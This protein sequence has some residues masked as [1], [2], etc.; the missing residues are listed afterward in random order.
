ML[1]GS[2]PEHS[3]ITVEEENVKYDII[4]SKEYLISDKNP[5]YKMNYITV[6]VTAN[7]FLTD[8]SLHHNESYSFSTG[9]RYPFD[10]S[11]EQGW[12]YFE[13]VF[14]NHPDNCVL[15]FY[16]LGLISRE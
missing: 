7:I 16:S 14:H 1:F 11:Q 2:Y 4:L 6:K 3:S 10:S 5:L 9:T 15:F 8:F 13:Y 12:K